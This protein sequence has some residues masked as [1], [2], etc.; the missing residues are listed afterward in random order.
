VF[1]WVI[2]PIFNSLSPLVLLIIN[3]KILSN[4]QKNFAHLVKKGCLKKKCPF[5]RF[6]CFE[7]A[8]TYLIVSSFENVNFAINEKYSKKH[9]DTPNYYVPYDF[10]NIQ[11]CNF[12]EC[13]FT[14]VVPLTLILHVLL[15]KKKEKKELDILTP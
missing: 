15:L 14:W 11:K 2:K 6:E 10:S 7:H 3:V 13:P 12:K 9:Y 4:F 1:K 8:K 5:S